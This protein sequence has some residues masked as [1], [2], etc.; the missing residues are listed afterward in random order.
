M[1]YVQRWRNLRRP[2]RLYL[3]HAALLTGSLAV[4]GLFFNLLVLALGYSLDFLGILNTVSLAV[5]AVLS[6]PLWWLVTRLGLRRAL[7]FSAA[8]QAAGTFL[9][10]LLPSSGALLVAVALTGVAAV[11]FQVSAPPFMMR[12]SDPSERDYLFSANA[13]VN[14][15]V[16]GIG[17]LIG[18]RLPGIFADFF[19]VAAESAVAYRATFAVAG[20][21]LAL[22]LVPLFLISRSNLE[23][24]PKPPADDRAESGAEAPPGEPAGLT[25]SSRGPGVGWWLRRVTRPRELLAAA[26]EPWAGLI[27]RPGPLLKLLVAPFF[28][29]WGAALLIPYLNLF[30][31][32]RFSIPDDTLGLVFAALNLATGLAAL[33]GPA[34]S[35]R[36]GKIGTVVLTQALS[37]PF[38]LA[39]GFAPLLSISVA[40][41]LARASLFN[42]GSPLYD[43]FAMEHTDEAARPLVIGL[44]NGA[45]SVGYLAA[46]LLSTT[47]QERFGFG[48][49]FAITAVC[50]SLAVVANYWFFIRSPMRPSPAV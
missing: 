7:A 46:P 43:A 14:V 12:Y 27:R 18:G 9:F 49:I 6:I 15:G 20:L 50:Y 8:L 45:Y 24:R 48:P 10:V 33:A 32:G 21:G 3:I 47:M 4:S 42:M 19:G 22:S 23:A 44:I 13:A 17:S 30:Y 26:P 2:A 5:A 31:K 28:I 25:R 11:L 35:G 39:L 16:A 41:A 40:A 1:S 34:L 36:I 37:I 38:L 29:S